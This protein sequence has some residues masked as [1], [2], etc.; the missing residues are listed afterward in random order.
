MQKQNRSERGQAIILIVFAIIGL[1]G[2]TA[3]AVDGGRAYSNRR[4]AQNTA[5]ATALEAAYT[6]VYGGNLYTEGLARAASNDFVDNNAA[7]GTSNPDVNIEIYN[8]PISGSYSG[9]AEYIQVFIT[10]NVQTFFGRVVGINEVT[11]KV[12]AVARARPPY[13]APIAFGNAI[14]GLSP[15]DCKAVMYQGN[16][17]TLVTGGGIYVNSNCAD[18]AFFNN[19]NAGSLTAPCLQAVGGI[20]Y[21]PGAVN[22]PEE[23]IITGA[24]PLPEITY[25]DPTCTDDAEVSGSSMGPGNYNGT[26]PP[27]GVTDLQPGVYC[28][29]GNFRLNGGD[30]L[31]GNDVVIVVE[32]GDV[33]WNGGAHIDLHA[34]T[35]GP[36]DGLLLHNEIVI[37]GDSTSVF[38]GTILAPSADIT[39]DGTGDAT[40]LNGQIIG[41]TVKLSGT[42]AMNIHYDDEDNWDVI[43][44]A[45]IE[46][47]E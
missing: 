25:P 44:P 15:D 24:S 23:C 20:V 40:G 16:A 18:S 28:V 13:T 41:Y 3:L 21:E 34:P 14:V 9:N 33:R 29:F 17:E 5:D 37:N 7:A 35:S 47:V 31:S 46:L 22:I 1:V 19:A 38:T 8:P 2:M 42:A 43:I 10:A 27:A 26:F 36:F 45:S 6:K 12:S 39:V 4:R 30:S 11:N 32:T